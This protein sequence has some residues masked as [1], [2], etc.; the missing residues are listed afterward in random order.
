MDE[1][2]IRPIERYCRADREHIEDAQE[3]MMMMV[4]KEDTKGEERS[5]EGLHVGLITEEGSHPVKDNKPLLRVCQCHLAME[6]N[7]Q[8]RRV[9]WC[10]WAKKEENKFVDENT[11]TM[12]GSMDVWTRKAT[13]QQDDHRVIYSDA[14]TIV[15][16]ISFNPLC[17]Q[18]GNALRT[19]NK[20]QP[21]GQILE[22]N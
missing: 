15:P 4:E 2:V 16:Q 21:E 20:S 17:L 18:Q 19:N 10:L 7:P 9:M 12:Q 1:D 3:M 11:I 8:T 5:W 22:V 13:W 14:I 6:A